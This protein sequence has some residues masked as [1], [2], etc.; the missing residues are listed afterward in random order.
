MG[1][2]IAGDYVIAGKIPV[3]LC[4]FD[5]P[6]AVPL[7][8]D[9][10]FTTLDNEAARAG[11]RL[12]LCESLPADYA[13]LIE[14]FQP[15]GAVFAYSSWSEEA[16]EIFKAHNIPCVAL[17]MFSEKYDIV[18]VDADWGYI[19]DQLIE[20][21]LQHDFRKIGLLTDPQ[22]YWDSECYD[23]YLATWKSAIQ[24]Y[25]LYDYGTSQQDMLCDDPPEVIIYYGKH[26]SQ[27]ICDFY[28]QKALPLLILNYAHDNS[29]R[30]CTFLRHTGFDYTMIAREGWKLL[31][32]LIKKEPL[33]E[34][35]VLL[36]FKAQILYHNTS[37]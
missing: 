25:D 24:K 8:N 32:K 15:A 37:Y 2:F 36:K 19:F 34:K 33:P 31:H 7:A 35:K 14:E 23:R 17:N 18:C 11:F 1:T 29:E 26:V 20:Q 16:G 3:I 10:L 5:S 6:H 30:D 9:I 22:G 21:L 4:F 12:C 13:A 28:R 27:K